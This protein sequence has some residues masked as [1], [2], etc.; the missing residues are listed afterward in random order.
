MQEEAMADNHYVSAPLGRV[1]FQT[2]APII[3]VMIVNGSFA[4]IDAYFL[5]K[6][7]GADAL[8]AVTLMFPLFM[9]LVALSTLVG[10]G[11]SSIMARQLGANRPE[12][13]GAT[14]VQSSL[15]SLIMAIILIVGFMVTGDWLVT[16]AADGNA[17]LATMGH[18]YISLTILWSPLVF[19][20]SINTDSLRAEGRV[21][22]MAAI[23]LVSALLNILFDY[24]FIA[25]LEM[26]VAGS[27]W[28]SIVAQA[29]AIAAIMV[30]RLRAGWG[31]QLNVSQFRPNMARWVEILSL[32][33]PASLGYLGFAI[34]SG[35]TIYLIQLHA[36]DYEATA[37]AYGI[38][39]RIM[40]FVF[41]PMLGLMF[42]TQSI[43]GNNFGADKQ[44][45]VDG[46]LKIAIV[47]AF[48]YCVAMQAILFLFRGAFGSIFVDDA[49]IISELA[50]IL[51]IGTLT[52]F[53]FG[54]Q[55]MI[56]IFFQAKGD[57]G[58]A[59]ILN[60]SRTYFFTIPL[61]IIM[62]MMMGEI[63]IWLSGAVAEVMVWILTIGVLLRI[64]T[65][66]WGLFQPT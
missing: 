7:V 27:A 56:G 19:F 16:R 2:A 54:P 4:P 49:A 52:L 3:T 48:V 64:K 38:L 61:I 55:M 18:T 66:K 51:P 63:G 12:A 9:F 59:A 24:I 46:A 58:R 36:V 57:A 41:L 39:N 8:T 17:D 35:L 22:A 60:L 13:A 53:I 40:T 45:R 11:L 65:H 47:A 20:L 31:F 62:P 6:Y 44:D 26:G 50:R 1:F 37:G 10:A 15:L 43:V 33:A 34:V 21:G 28:G 42:A 5:G 23:S 29:L 30:Y 32:G 14:Y 25:I